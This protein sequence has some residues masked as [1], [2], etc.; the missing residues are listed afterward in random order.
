LRK[1]KIYKS[2]KFD[3]IFSTDEGPL[4]KEKFNLRKQIQNWMFKDLIGIFQDLIDF[5]EV[6][7]ARKIDF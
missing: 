7:I 2:E 1:I 6:L 3:G 4:G 5:I